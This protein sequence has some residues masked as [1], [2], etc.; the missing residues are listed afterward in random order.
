MIRSILTVDIDTEM[1]GRHRAPHESIQIIKTCIV[2]PNVLR[3]AHTIAFS[4]VSV[5]FP[6]VKPVKR[7][8]HKSLRTT[9]KASRPIII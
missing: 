5:Q 3:R 8:P 1:S 6:K 9:F 4:K 7:A 2:E